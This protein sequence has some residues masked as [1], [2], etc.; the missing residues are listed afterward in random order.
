M[1]EKLSSHNLKNGVYKH[2][3][4]VQLL[5]SKMAVKRATESGDLERVSRAYYSTAD[6][7]YLESHFLVIKRFY[8]DAVISKRT[9]LYHYRL[10]TDQPS[11]IDIDVGPESHLRNSTDLVRVYRTKKIFS[12]IKAQFHSVSLECYSLERA[13]FE[14]LYFETTPGEL[15]S[16]V[17]HNYL[18][19][20]KYEPAKIQKIAQK[21]GGRGAELANIIRILAGHKFVALG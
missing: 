12:T 3:E 14:V 7:P 17:I 11:T 8:P 21:F 1:S 6:V 15:T 20:Y 4:L 18:A 13:L 9:L 5:G 2:S 10:T 19:K 16:E